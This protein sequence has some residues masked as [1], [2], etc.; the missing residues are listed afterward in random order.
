LGKSSLVLNY[1]HLI[2]QRENYDMC[3]IYAT[4]YHAAVCGVLETRNRR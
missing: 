1:F 3:D 4:L 2:E